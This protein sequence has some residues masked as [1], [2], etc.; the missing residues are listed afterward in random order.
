MT[1]LIDLRVHPSSATICNEFERG[2]RVATSKRETDLLIGEGGECRVTPG[3]SRDFVIV[4]VFVD[5][6]F[7]TGDD[8]SADDEKG[9]L[10]A[11]RSRGGT[12]CV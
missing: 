5:D 1:S 10:Y 4:H 7:W 8:A 9:G 2:S 6:D 12:V 3:V 11:W